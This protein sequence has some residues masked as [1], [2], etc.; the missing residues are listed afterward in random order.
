M[1]DPEIFVQETRTQKMNTHTVYWGHGYF[2]LFL[3][4]WI[5][6]CVL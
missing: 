6:C 4:V 2:F 5:Y 3:F 1:V